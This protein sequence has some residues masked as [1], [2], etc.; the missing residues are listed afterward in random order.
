MSL[1]VCS[2]SATQTVALLPHVAHRTFR[3]QVNIAMRIRRRE[4]A[5]TSYVWGILVDWKLD[6]GDT[7]HPLSTTH[8]YTSCVAST[9]LTANNIACTYHI[10][11]IHISCFAEALT[12]LKAGPL[13]WVYSPLG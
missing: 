1:F 9:V 7:I 5:H 13:F 12:K 10:E 4:P 2:C 3:P 8:M 11:Y 6:F